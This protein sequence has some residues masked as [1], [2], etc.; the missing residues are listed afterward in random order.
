MDRGP[1]PSARAPATARSLAR[2]AKP[3]LAAGRA[4]AP[5]IRVCYLSDSDPNMQRGW[6]PWMETV[7][8]RTGRHRI[9]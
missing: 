6:M 8:L 4:I 9:P 2:D 3:A 5:I 1:T 7:P